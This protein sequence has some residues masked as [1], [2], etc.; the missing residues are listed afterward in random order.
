MTLEEL[1]QYDGRN[2]RKAY[3]AVQGKIYDVTQSPL[4]AGGDHQG[5]HQAG[6]DLTE[7]LKS[8]PHVRAVIDRFPVVAELTAAEPSAGGRKLAAIAALV[9]ALAALALWLL[10]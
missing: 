1:S 9:I 10:L 5:D 2:G 8:A 7:E 3:V 6:G 4:W